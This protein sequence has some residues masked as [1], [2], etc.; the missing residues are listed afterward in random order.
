MET[1]IAPLLAL[2]ERERRAGRAVALAVV[3]NTNGST[4]RKPGALM[5]I[6]ADGEYAG[7]LS[8][9][10]LEADL[11]QHALQVMSSGTAKLLTYD[12]GGSDDLLWGLGVGCEGV[13]QI[14][15]MRAGDENG[16]QPLELFAT[17]QQRHEQAVAAVV[18]ASPDTALPPGSI[19][20][21]EGQPGGVSVP[22]SLQ[23]A[24]QALLTR[25]LETGRPNALGASTES[26]R[27]LALPLALPPRLLLLGGGPDAQ[28]L[29]D[30]AARLTWHIT[31]YDH[32]SAYAQTVRFPRAEQVVLGHPDG[33]AQTLDLNCFD[34]AIVMSHHLNSDLAYLRALSVS[35][36]PYI[37]LL[38]PTNR[39]DKLL[40]NLGS[41]AAGL[42]GRL[43]S[44]I[45]L[46]IGGRSPESI[47]LS[48]V[49]EIHARLHGASGG[50]FEGREH[51]QN[52]RN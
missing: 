27:V 11:H 36:I 47:A 42:N 12:T 2:Y 19:V 21:R 45:G 4:Y 18:V 9:G 20:M 13:M 7:L 44:P 28:P 5:L 39:R 33:L 1:L 25:A 46:N 31:V 15:L 40:G 37:G 49:A 23:D 52:E 35:S 10:C 34:A 51:Y 24:I 14:L 38:G 6:A 22:E 30:L 48:I 8:G 50:P 43:R 32:R 3:V 41:D 16:W 26:L 29:V 17:A